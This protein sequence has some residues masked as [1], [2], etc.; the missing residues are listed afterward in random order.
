MGVVAGEIL[1]PLSFFS[2]PELQEIMRRT[3]QKPLTV[4]FIKT[5]QKNLP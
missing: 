3:P 1:M 5:A 2:S 4:H